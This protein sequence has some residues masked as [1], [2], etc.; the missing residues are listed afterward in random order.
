MYSNAS[1]LAFNLSYRSRCLRFSSFSSSSSTATTS[2]PSSTASENAKLKPILFKD[3]KPGRYNPP[4]RRIAKIMYALLIDPRKSGFEA[5]RDRY[6]AVEDLLSHP[7]L[8]DTDI[9]T[10]EH[11][12]RSDVQKH[13]HFLFRARPLPNGQGVGTAWVKARVEGE[14]I[15]VRPSLGLSLKGSCLKLHLLSLV[16]EAKLT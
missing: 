7:D 6:V 1:K 15:P 3:P 8:A 4:T 16:V 13:F 9:L 2:R 10:V 11:I 14:N 5:T 12:V